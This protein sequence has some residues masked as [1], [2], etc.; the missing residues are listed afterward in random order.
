MILIKWGPDLINRSWGFKIRRRFS[1]PR[2]ITGMVRRRLPHLCPTTHAAPR[3]PH[4]ISFLSFP[5]SLSLSLS[6][7]SFLPSSPLIHTLTQ[8]LLLPYFLPIAHT[9]SPIDVETQPLKK[10]KTWVSATCSKR[11]KN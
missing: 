2:V 4:L 10:K 9:P 3:V 1:L 5:L 8:P 7:F 11:G 6:L